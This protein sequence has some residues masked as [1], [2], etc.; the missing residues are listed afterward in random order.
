[1]IY[2]IKAKS[3]PAF[4]FIL[5]VLPFVTSGSPEIITGVDEA[6]GN[7]QYSEELLAQASTPPI[8]SSSVNTRSAT[9]QSAVSSAPAS[10]VP[11]TQYTQP[12][13][14]PSSA[15]TN[16]SRPPAI[17]SPNSPYLFIPTGLVICKA[18]GLLVC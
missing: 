1:M 9:Q 6:I 10:Q 14:S 15:Q 18:T 4:C 16:R 12:R 3:H 2:Q 17:G 11:A 7:F 5:I 8:A 13:P